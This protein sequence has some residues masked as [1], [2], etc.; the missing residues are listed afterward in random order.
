VKRGFHDGAVVCALAAFDRA[1][2][3]SGI[4]WSDGEWDH[5]LKE[6]ENQ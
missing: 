5:K 3:G 6:N 4:Y 2:N 1:G